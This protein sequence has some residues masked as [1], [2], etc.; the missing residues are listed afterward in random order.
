MVARLCGPVQLAPLDAASS[1]H[2]MY[3]PAPRDEMSI[4]AKGMLVRLSRRPWSIGAKTAKNQ[5]RPIAS[6]VPSTHRSFNIRGGRLCGLTFELRPPP[7]V[8]AWAARPMISTTGSR[9][10]CQ[11]V[12][13]R[14]ERRVRRQRGSATVRNF[15]LAPRPG[16]A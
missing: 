5:T 13:G 10:K 9:P 1:F 11:A 2:S 12:E 15:L 14:L 6:A 8:G 4:A 7:R 16:Q 3:A